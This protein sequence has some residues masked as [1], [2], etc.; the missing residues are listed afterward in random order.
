MRVF[1]ID[2]IVLV[3]IVAL[4]ALVAFGAFDL[5]VQSDNLA[6][7]PT[8]ME[9]RRLEWASSCPKD[10]AN[11]PALAK[12]APTLDSSGKVL[13]S[14]HAMDSLVGGD[15]SSNLPVGP[16]AWEVSQVRLYLEN[17]GV[18]PDIPCAVLLRM[19]GTQ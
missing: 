16:S 18:K 2:S 10:S 9:Q 8:E 4:A 6:G 19:L 11:P 14:Q 7:K 12:I 5:K 17:G 1:A 13:F 3:A 15:V